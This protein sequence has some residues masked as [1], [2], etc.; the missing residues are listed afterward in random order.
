MAL[1]GSRALLI[2]VLCIFS[3]LC[4]GTYHQ[5]FSEFYPHYGEVLSNQIEGQHNVSQEQ[6]DLVGGTNC[7]AEYTT[8]I[9]TRSGFDATSACYTGA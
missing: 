6:L 2:L 5:K 3:R 8:Y 1:V 9:E 7:S 4:L